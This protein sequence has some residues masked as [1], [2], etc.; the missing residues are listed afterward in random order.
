MR[1]EEPNFFVSLK[2]IYVK[3]K[4]QFLKNVKNKKTGSY[5]IWIPKNYSCK[6][7]DNWFLR[8]LSP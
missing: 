5:G 6:E 2:F 7:R 4:N 8:G 3:K 1:K